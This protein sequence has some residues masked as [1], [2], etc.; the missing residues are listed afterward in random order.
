MK[1]LK[2]VYNVV[3]LYDVDGGFGDAVPRQE[4]VFTFENREDAETFA[5]E[6]QN[7]HIYNEP[8]DPLEC[9]RLEVKPVEIITTDDFDVSKFKKEQF[10]WFYRGF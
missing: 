6:F 8:Y 7:R 9:G 10:W 2:F 3:H 1:V 4:T 5:K